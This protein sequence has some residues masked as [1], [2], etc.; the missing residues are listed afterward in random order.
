MENKSSLLEFHRANWYNS[1]GIDFEAIEPH[2]QNL[3]SMDELVPTGPRFFIVLNLNTYQY[4][5]LGKGQQLMTGYD[6][7]RVSKEGVSFQTAQ[8]HP[9]DGEYIVKNSYGKFIEVLVAHPVE[10]AKNIILQNNYR[11]R[12]KNGHY[13][14]LMEQA[15]ILQFDA[16]GK[17]L[18]A[19]VHIYQ[20]P[21]IHPFRVHVLIKKRINPHDYAVIYSQSFPENQPLSTL[22]P[23]ETELIRLLA[24]G[25]TSKEI[26]DRLC[27][28]HHTVRTHRKNILQKLQMKSTNELIAY[29]ITQGMFY[30]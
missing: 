19:V 20:L 6:N 24:E 4:E 21:M 16:E 23:R 10:E 2:I 28:S 25:A 9:E 13:I 5:F 3:K 14:H 15:W 26:A 17:P 8:L 1:A 11:F 27:I 12:H 29:C 7:E 18:L 30:S 22:S